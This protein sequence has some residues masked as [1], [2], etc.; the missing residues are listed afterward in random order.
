[1]NWLTIVVVIFLAM[2]AIIG[3]KKGFLRMLFTA[4]AAIISLILTIA[5]YP[6]VGSL[7]CD[8][9]NF[10]EYLEEKYSSYIEES[11]SESADEPSFIIK[12]AESMSIDTEDETFKSIADY[13]ESGTSATG[14]AVNEITEELRHSLT[15][16]LVTATINVVSFIITWILVG[17]ITAI[18]LSIIKIIEKIPVIKGLNRLLGLLLGILIGLLV[19]WLF[20][21]I[22]TGLAATSF[23]S[24]CIECIHESELLTW[25]YKANIFTRIF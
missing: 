9:T 5:L 14:E 16:K 17:L 8:N 6:H 21:T 2:M 19:V 20:F 11:E 24:S 3:I 23:G 4:C 10:D 13:V 12:M 7:I 1:M 22:V 18:L 25:L 15:L